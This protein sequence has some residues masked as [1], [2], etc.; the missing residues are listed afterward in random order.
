MRNYQAN[1]NKT[2][3]S[4]EPPDAKQIAEALDDISQVYHN[5][6]LLS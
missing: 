4:F 6:F 5:C 2:N 3:M 1:Y